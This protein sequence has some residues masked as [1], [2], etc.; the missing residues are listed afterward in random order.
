MSSNRRF[1]S[2]G[3]FSN[4]GGALMLARQTLIGSC[5]WQLDADQA[6]PEQ[7]RDVAHGSHVAGG[8]M[9]SRLF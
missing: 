6:L 7:T 5:R 3:G 1:F 9:V 4:S 2:S 8:T